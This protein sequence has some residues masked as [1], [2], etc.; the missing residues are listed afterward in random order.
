MFFSK[1]MARNDH[2]VIPSYTIPLLIISGHYDVIS[3]NSKNYSFHDFFVSEWFFRDKNVFIEIS[4]VNASKW[5]VMWPCLHYDPKNGQF[6]HF[7]RKIITTSGLIISLVRSKYFCDQCFLSFNLR[8]HT[9]HKPLI[10][11]KSSM[12]L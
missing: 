7:I 12:R 11:R 4:I 6:D 5:W 9:W 8:Y 1:N 10:Y 3:K 2:L